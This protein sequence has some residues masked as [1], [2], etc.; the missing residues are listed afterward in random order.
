MRV[1]YKLFSSLILKR[2]G[3]YAEEMLGV[4]QCAFGVG[5]GT[6]DQILVK[7]QML[8]KCYEYDIDLHLLFIDYKKAFN[9]IR[10]STL[11]N[12]LVKIGVLQKLINL[13][14]L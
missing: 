13:I 14:G 4:C 6:T 2:L 3:K 12:I 7:K 5:R 8:E 10:R 11:L 1:L 9:S